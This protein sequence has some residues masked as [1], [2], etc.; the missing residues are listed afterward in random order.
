MTSIETDWRLA[1]NVFQTSKGSTSSS[2]SL[3]RLPVLQWWYMQ[4]Q[5]CVSAALPLP[6]SYHPVKQLWHWFWRCLTHLSHC[7]SNGRHFGIGALPIPAQALS[8]T[9]ISQK[10]FYIVRPCVLSCYRERYYANLDQLIFVHF[11]TVEYSWKIEYSVQM[12]ASLDVELHTSQ[13]LG[14]S[15]VIWLG[16]YLATA[17]NVFQQTWSRD[18]N[19]PILSDII[20]RLHMSHCMSISRHSQNS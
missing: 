17:K 9:F 1:P 20:C 10:N 11:W 15:I 3:C 2:T 8:E 14:E 12:R 6:S 7:C 18:G 19:P 13:K 5:S 4:A 16:P